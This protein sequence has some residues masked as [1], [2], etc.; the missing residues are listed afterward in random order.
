LY[1]LLAL[2]ELYDSEVE[3]AVAAMTKDP[4]RELNIL[5]SQLER[6]F[7]AFCA[8]DYDVDLT[9]EITA[10]VLKAVRPDE[11]PDY[12]ERLGAFAAE[13]RRDLEL[14]YRDYGPGSVPASLGTY[15]LA[16]QPESVAIF[17]RL[18]NAPRALTQAWTQTLPEQLLDDMKGVW[19][20]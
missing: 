3:R 10:V 4:D 1:R 5:V 6:I 13:M 9:R 17:E 2:V 15:I 16:S 12:P 8:S 20:A 18:T 19:A 11:R 7:Y 14:A